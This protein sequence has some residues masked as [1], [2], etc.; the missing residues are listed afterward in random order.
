MFPVR[1]L[2]CVV[3]GDDGM[4]EPRTRRGFASMHPMVQWMP[5][6][7]GQRLQ[8]RDLHRPAEPGGRAPQ[9]RR[10]HPREGVH[11]R[12]D[13][14]GGHTRLHRLPGRA[15]DGDQARLALHEHVVGPLV[16]VRPVGAVPGDV[17]GDQPRVRGAERRG[18][19]T[20]PGGRALG[21]VLYEHV[22]VGDQPAARRRG[23]GG[24]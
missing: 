19:Q 13:V 7:L 9:Q 4:R 21:E 15:G 23:R 12:R 1:R 20:E 2:E 16:C 3:G 5:H 24:P 8:H 14:G 11:R 17:D 22:G 18:V 6:P 10:E